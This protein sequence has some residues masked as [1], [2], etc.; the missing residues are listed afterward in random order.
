MR[1]NFDH[2]NIMAIAITI[3]ENRLKRTIWLLFGS[4]LLF[5]LGLLP[6]FVEK[7]YSLGFYPLFANFLR[8]LTGWIPFSFGDLLYIGFGVWLLVL[9]RKGICVIFNKKITTDL[10]IHLLGNVIRFFSWI[11][12]LFKLFWGMNYSRLGIEQQLGIKKYQYTKDDITLLTKQLI[13]QTN[14]LRRAFQDST[15]PQYSL[16]LLKLEAIKSYHLANAKHSFLAYNN[17]SVKESLFTPLANYIGFT[18]YYNPFT[19]EAQLRTDVP[20]VL[21]PYITCHEMAHQLGYANESEA[22]FVGY[23]AASNSNNLY[24]KYSV[25]LD[26]LGYALTQQ[27]I[28]Y[29]RDS[30]YK[31]FEDIVKYNKSNIDTLVKKDRKEIRQFFITRKNKISP[32]SADLYDQY[33]K[34]NKQ[35]AGINSYDEVIGWMIAYQK[36]YK[37]L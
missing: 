37:K 31:A 7:W 1:T 25:Y 15:L 23:L 5:L 4:L 19:G 33:L 35:L 26:L 36:K 17:L 24:F 18:G 20:N 12:I 29:A 34:M 13:K 22:N 11:Y 32:I 21:T 3:H 28:L 9:L 8:I 14:V 30:S 10:I 27:F 2:S 16:D 6:D